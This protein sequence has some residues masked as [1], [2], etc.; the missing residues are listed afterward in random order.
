M[1]GMKL[2]DQKLVIL[3]SSVF[4]SKTVNPGRKHCQTK[5]LICKPEIVHIYINS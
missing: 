1:I 5:D 3:L 2:L 4:G